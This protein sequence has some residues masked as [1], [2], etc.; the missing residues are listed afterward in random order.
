MKPPDRCPTAVILTPTQKPYPPHKRHIIPL[1]WFTVQWQ[2]MKF[3]NTSRTFAVLESVLAA[4]ICQHSA[5]LNSYCVEAAILY[6]FSAAVTFLLDVIVTLST[7]PVTIFFKSCRY[8][9]DDRTKL[10]H[11]EQLVHLVRAT[12]SSVQIVR[13]FAFLT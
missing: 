11:S 13:N 12:L 6:Q 2:K 3:N 1:G 8:A 9:R 5:Q 7:P 4:W 10:A